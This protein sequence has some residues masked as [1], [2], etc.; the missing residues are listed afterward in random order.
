MYLNLASQAKLFNE[1]RF[2]QQ[3][4]EETSLAL[5]C[6]VHEYEALT[7]FIHYVLI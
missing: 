1:F 3:A 6:M 5:A 2:P 4:G 7:N